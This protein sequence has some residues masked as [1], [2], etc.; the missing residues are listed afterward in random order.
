MKKPPKNPFH[1]Y[2]LEKISS[3]NHTYSP[4]IRLKTIHIQK[5]IGLR[6][7]AAMNGRLARISFQVYELNTMAD[8]LKIPATDL[9]AVYIK[10]R[11]KP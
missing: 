5:A 7:S 3:Y 11:H 2:I 10:H 1:A 4:T 6:S 8:I 9:H